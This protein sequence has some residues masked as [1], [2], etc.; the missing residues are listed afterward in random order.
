M[1]HAVPADLGRSVLVLGTQLLRVVRRVP[2]RLDVLVV[3]FGVPLAPRSGLR[4]A[5]RRGHDDEDE[6]RSHD[7][8]CRKKNLENSAVEV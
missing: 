5:E 8:T 2:S 4:A 6:C 1:H 3:V 7:A